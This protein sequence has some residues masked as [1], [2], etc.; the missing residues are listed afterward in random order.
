MVF[1]WAFPTPNLILTDIYMHCDESNL[2]KKS[3]FPF[4][5]R[6]VGNCFTLLI[7]DDL[8]LSNILDT[9]KFIDEHFQFTSELENNNHLPCVDYMVFRKNNSFL[10]IVY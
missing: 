10:T 6:Y 1:S 5:S 2:F 8:N 7:S 4:F 9:M 3:T